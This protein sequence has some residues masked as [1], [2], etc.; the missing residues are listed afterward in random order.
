MREKRICEVCMWNKNDICKKRLSDNYME[1]TS[2]ITE[3]DMYK[4]TADKEDVEL[5]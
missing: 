5:K 1:S 2:F 3:C 4:F